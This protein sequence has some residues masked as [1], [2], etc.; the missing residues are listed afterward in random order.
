MTEQAGDATVGRSTGGA[1]RAMLA[2]MP[3]IKAEIEIEAPQGPLFALAQDYGLRLEW[4]PF[5]REMKFKGG[6][7]EAAVGVRVWVRAHNGMTMEVEYITLKPPDQ[8][9]MRMVDGPKMFRQFSG[10]WLFKPVTPTRTRVIFRYNFAT[11]PTI[12]A[13][14]M[15]PIVGK[16]LLRDMEGRLAGLKKAAETTDILKRLGT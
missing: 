12:V 7:R 16:V 6:A 4:D 15:A 11:R 13:W 14:A 1:V 8:V 2:A 9:A 5:L 3:T 10:A